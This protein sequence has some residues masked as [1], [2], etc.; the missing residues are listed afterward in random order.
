MRIA[1]DK[2]IALKS[3][4]DF[5]T[6]RFE[7]DAFDAVL[8]DA[9]LVQPADIGEIIEDVVRVARTSGDVAVF[10]PTAGSFGEVVSL[11]W[12]V[13]LTRTSVNTAPRRNVDYRHPDSFTGRGNGRKGGPGER[14]Q[15]DDDR[16]I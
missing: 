15:R 8:A 12:E 3:D 1:Q 11:L 13:F 5:S 2:A 16:D 14:K 6:L 9:S 7:D 10:L 4:V